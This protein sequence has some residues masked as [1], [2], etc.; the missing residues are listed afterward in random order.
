MPAATAMAPGVLGCGSPGNAARGPWGECP[1]AGSL[2]S[3]PW[4]CSAPLALALLQ[5]Q[6]DNL[7]DFIT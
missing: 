4:L 3:A 6:Q 5:G 7:E 1:T 2:L